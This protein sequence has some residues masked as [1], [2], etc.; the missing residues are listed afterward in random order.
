MRTR[1]LAH[2]RTSKPAWRV[3]LADG[4]ELVAS[5]DHRFL[6]ERGWKFVA[7]AE[8]FQR[9]R[10][11]L[12]NTLMGFGKTPQSVDRSALDQRNIATDISR[13]IIRGDGHLG[14]YR[15]YAAGPKRTATS[16]N[17]GSR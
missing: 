5:G 4:T 1:V 12:N 13:G 7:T 17:F 6:T 9:P 3:R 8:Q 11:T 2:W 16:T 15:Y 14:V 10:L